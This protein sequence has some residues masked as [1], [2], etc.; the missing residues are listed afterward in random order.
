MVAVTS[1][2]YHTIQ[3]LEPLTDLFWWRWDF[4][5]VV[6]SRIYHTIQSLEPLTYILYGGDGTLWLR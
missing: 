6:T 4:V 3:S 1:R 5:V 2:I